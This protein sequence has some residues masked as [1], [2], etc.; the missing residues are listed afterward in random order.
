MNPQVAFLLSKAME[1][2]QES[3]LAT[4]EIYLMQALKIQPKNFECLRL[5]GI[6]YALKGEYQ[7][8][9]TRFEQAIVLSPKSGIAYSN[10]GN[11]LRELGRFEDAILCYDKAISL[12]PKYH[13]AH[14]NKGNALQELGRFEDAVLCYDKAISLMPNYH[15]AY[16]GKGN[17]LQEL[18]RFEDAVLCYDKAISLMPNYHEAYNGKGLVLLKIKRPKESILCFDKAI[19]LMPRYHEAHNN[20]GNALQD[21]SRFEDAILCYDKA[22]LIMPNYHEAYTNKGGALRLAL[23]YC[24]AIN[25]YDDALKIEPRS[26]EA[27]SGKGLIFFELRQVEKARAC[28]KNALTINPNHINTKYN[29]SHLELQE[30]NFKE[31]WDHYEYRWLKSDFDSP[32]MQTS[33]P[34]WQGDFKD[35]RLL[36]WSEQGIG[37]QILYSSMLN[38]LDVMVG[39]KAVRLDKKLIKIFQRSFP[40]YNFISKDDFIS[41]QDFDVQIPMGS[42]GRIFRTSLGSFCKASHPYIFDD[43]ARTESI[44]D[45]YKCLKTVTCGISWGSTNRQVGG[46]KSIPINELYPILRIKG[47]E[48]FNLQSGEVSTPLLQVKQDLL[49]EILYLDEIDLYDDVDGALS[50]ISACDIIVTCSNTT[51]HLAGA[52]GKE[53]LLLL[54][55]SAGQFWYWQAIDGKSIWYPSVKVFEQEQQG[56]WSAPVSAVKQYLESRFG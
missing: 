34:Q 40:N 20:K 11:V 7:E 10:K 14:N 46:H 49:K 52:L 13:E 15:E 48:F 4:A 53:T 3:S 35:R 23:N 2:I 32:R 16:N 39:S 41:E 50:I 55:Y 24:G 22:I 19:S 8:A 54:P 27:W 17:A 37:D 31:G 21:L 47:I 45:Q 38:E 25:S 33:R 18:D 43:A 5:I 12:M 51:A 29:L 42:L 28:Y 44:K 56:D 1:S 26:F 9:L 30:F 6:T 36:V